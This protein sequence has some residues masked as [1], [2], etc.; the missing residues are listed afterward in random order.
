V[1]AFIQ[2]LLNLVTLSTVAL[3]VGALA[4]IAY[5][6]YNDQQECNAQESPITVTAQDCKKQPITIECLLQQ[7]GLRSIDVKC[8]D[9]DHYFSLFSYKKRA[10]DDL[11]TSLFLS[12][13]SLL[14]VTIVNYLF[15][16]RATIW[17][18]AP[19]MGKKEPSSPNDSS[20]TA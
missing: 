19:S 18:R 10:L 4:L 20:G 9:D 17:N 12:F 2:R 7:R 13:I 6:F 5:S 14:G 11:A 8:S 15:F 16:G 1:S 3:T